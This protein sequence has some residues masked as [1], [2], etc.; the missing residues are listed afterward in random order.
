MAN[1]WKFETCM[2]TVLPAGQVFLVIFKQ[3]ILARKF[4]YMF[5][6]YVGR[7]ITIGGLK[8]FIFQTQGW[9]LHLVWT[10]TVNENPQKCL[11]WTFLKKISFFH[12]LW[13]VLKNYKKWLKLTCLVTLFDRKLTH[14]NGLFLA[15]LINFCPLKM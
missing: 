1:F 9:T 11:I 4:K 15:C 14:Q 12:N 8:K 13:K 6:K 10:N 7:F 3:I 5:E 2:Q